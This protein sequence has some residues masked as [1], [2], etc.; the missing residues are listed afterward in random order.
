MS[1]RPGERQ[2]RVQLSVLDRLLDED[3]ERGTD[4]PLGPSET[5][6]ELRR[7]AQRDLE[8][9]LN[10]RQRWRSWPA[11][12]AELAVSPYAFGVPDFTSGYF[13]SEERREA[14]RRDVA[15]VI[16]AYEPRL[17]AVKVTLVPGADE[18]DR[19]LRLRVEA[20]MLAD[21]E[22]EPVSFDTAF[23]SAAMAFIVQGADA[24]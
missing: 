11:S 12:F 6:A 15:A 21:P 19:T 10:A 17:K 9:L 4:R 16:A 5:L 24:V 13:A 23:D 18:T 20:L 3:S 1:L 14:F 7:A 8:A 22:P 2:T